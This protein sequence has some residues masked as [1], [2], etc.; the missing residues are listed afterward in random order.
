[1]QPVALTTERLILR[2]WSKEDLEPFAQLNGNPQ[3]MEFFPALLTQLQSD[4]LAVR[5]KTGIELSGW[6]MWA[7]TLKKPDVF[8]GF[9]GLLQVDPPYP[10]APAVE[11]GWRLLPAYWG[12]GLATEGALASLHFGFTTLALSEIVSMTAVQ[13]TRSRHVMERIGMHFSGEFD[14]PKLP[15]ESPLRR[16]VLYRITRSESLFPEK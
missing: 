8:I 7:A 9:I 10:F 1:M 2:Q 12:Q 3:V 14:H 5:F 16:H 4:A 11:V 6:G 15:P 13:N